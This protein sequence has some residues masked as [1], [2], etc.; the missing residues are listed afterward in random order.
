MASLT[1]HHLI[2]SVVQGKI[3]T[4]SESRKPRRLDRLENDGPTPLPTGTS[5][6]LRD[7]W[8]AE[9]ASLPA[10]AIMNIRWANNALQRYELRNCDWQR[11]RTFLPVLVPE[12]HPPARVRRSEGDVLWY[13]AESTR[14]PLSSFWLLQ[15]PLARL[16]FRASHLGSC[17][18]RQRVASSVTPGSA[19]LN[20]AVKICHLLFHL[21]QHHNTK[22]L[23]QTRILA[24]L[25]SS[26]LSSCIVGASMRTLHIPSGCTPTCQYDSS[27]PDAACSFGGELHPDYC[28]M[29]SNGRP[30]MDHFVTSTMDQSTD[31]E[32]GRMG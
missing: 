21:R 5:I 10:V 18:S 8:L 12:L 11:S 15:N 22:L 1:H 24:L 4:K 30:C 17:G 9:N 27:S 13:R 3:A 26:I 23:W 14:T 16:T 31:R 2:C 7:F 6:R 19:L 28:G 29:R 20:V 25:T 32:D